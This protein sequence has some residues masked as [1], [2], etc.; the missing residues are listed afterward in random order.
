VEARDPPPAAALGEAA[1]DTSE[2]PGRD[3]SSDDEAPA[4]AAPSEIPRELYLVN[5][6][7][8]AYHAAEVIPAGTIL[9][10]PLQ[11]IEVGG[12]HVKTCCGRRLTM[13]AALYRLEESP[14]IALN[15]CHLKACQR[16]FAVSSQPAA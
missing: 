7:T 1:S 3:S 11:G 4:S 14:P 8:G 15:P 16:S 2:E 5:F 10:S 9:T 12:L 13:G 6:V